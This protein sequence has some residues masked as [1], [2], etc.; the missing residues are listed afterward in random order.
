MSETR[1]KR[2]ALYQKYVNLIDRIGQDAA[3]HAQK[4]PDCGAAPLCIGPA[5]M[6]VLADMVRANQIEVGDMLY[7]AIHEI[8]ALRRQLKDT[9]R[10]LAAQRAATSEALKRL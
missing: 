2:E 3:E 9:E 6:M 5:P 1:E 8:H 4:T 7:V 10:R